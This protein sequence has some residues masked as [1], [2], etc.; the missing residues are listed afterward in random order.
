MEKLK[1]AILDLYDG[2]PNQGM[3]CIK[4]IVNQFSGDIV[5]KVFD[6]RGNAEIPD[7]EEYDIF[8]GT[9]GPGSPYDGDGI[10]DTAYFD[11]MQKIWEHN[12]Q[13]VDQPKFML[14]ICHSFQMAC[15][16]FKVAEVTRRKSKSFG[17]FPVHKTEFGK[18]EWIFETLPNPFWIADFRDWQVVK[19]DYAR[20]AELGAKILLREKI[21][22]TV[23]LERAIMGIRFSNEMFG[24][25]FHPEADPEGMLVHFQ[26]DKQRQLIED[27]HGVEKY[28]EMINDLEDAQRIPLTHTTIIPLFLRNAVET[29]QK[30]E[31]V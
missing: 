3:R 4:E 29:L 13:T 9:G 15:R 24:T 25:Q 7:L 28:A 14:F 22:P 27:E 11:L 30:A 23:P 18:R 10:W 31:L 5:W 26:D 1:L 8:I 21:R 19:P 2:T 6:T 17:T 16:H 20:L 12:Q